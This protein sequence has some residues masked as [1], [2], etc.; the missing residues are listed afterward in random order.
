LV[1][2]VLVHA[3][4]SPLGPQGLHLADSLTGERLPVGAGG[5]DRGAAPPGLSC[6]PDQNVA[7]VA[8]GGRAGDAE[9][10][11]KCMQRVHRLP[12]LRLS[13]QHAQLG[14]FLWRQG[15]PVSTAPPALMAG[16]R[17]RVL[18]DGGHADWIG[19]AGGDLP[20]GVS[21]PV[22]VVDLDA[23]GPDLP[24]AERVKD[25]RAGG[26]AASMRARDRRRSSQ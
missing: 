7:T 22:Q 4:A 6:R 14:H 1:T 5:G 18:M 9:P 16:G 20:G 12:I 17:G 3:F 2:R 24:D 11:G 10:G 15:M 19:Q 26:R 25:A 21:G 8:G 23:H 13:A